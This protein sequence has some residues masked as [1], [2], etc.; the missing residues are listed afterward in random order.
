M[1]KRGIVFRKEMENTFPLGMEEI[2]SQIKE[3]VSKSGE[4][5]RIYSP[6]DG[7]LIGR[8]KDAYIQYGYVVI[9]IDIK[10]LFTFSELDRD[11]SLGLCLMISQD[12]K[13]F[14]VDKILFTEESKVHGLGIFDDNHYPGK[15]RMYRCG[16]KYIVEVESELGTINHEVAE[17]KFG[18]HSNG[19]GM[20]FDLEINGHKDISDYEHAVQEDYD[21][22]KDR[23]KGFVI[24]EMEGIPPAEKIYTQEKVSIDD[25]GNMKSYRETL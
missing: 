1:I 19:Y 4:E 3:L 12:K 2:V 14:H 23:S 9:D 25:D 8:I 13:G 11:R 6:Y 15:E 22:Y 21:D 5:N 16:E 24:P 10:N 18:K 20:Y 7:Q 17:V